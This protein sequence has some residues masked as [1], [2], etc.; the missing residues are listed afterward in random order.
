MA[1]VQDDHVIQAFTADTPDEP[2][3]IGVLPRIPGA[4]TTSSIPIFRT[5]CRNEAP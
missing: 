4:M 2:F 5:R 1:L 3:D